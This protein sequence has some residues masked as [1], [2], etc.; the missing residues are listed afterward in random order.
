MI[1]IH[2][3]AIYVHQL[4]EVARFFETYFD[5]HRIDSYH[6]QNTGFLSRFLH[7]NEGAA[8]ELM[9]RPDVSDTTDTATHFGLHHLSLSVG[10][11][12]MVDTLTDKLAKDGYSVLSQPRT[13]GDG[14]YESCIQGPE[15]IIIE[16]TV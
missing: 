10:S 12:K 14:Y 2:H 15:N 3:I 7:L 5:I 11:K 6:N 8:I 16:I 9:N 4:D 1:R 13:T